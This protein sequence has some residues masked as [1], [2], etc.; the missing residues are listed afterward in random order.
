MGLAT[1]DAVFIRP[2]LDVTGAPVRNPTFVT[3]SDGG[4]RNAYELRLRNKHG[5]PRTFRVALTGDPRLNLTLEGTPYQAI[6][7]PADAT[8]KLRVYVTAPPSSDPA[9]ADVTG[10]RFWIED[11]ANGDRAYKDSTFNGKGRS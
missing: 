7:V 11:L 9:Q 10:F 2:D 8:H 5:E 3:L 6:E 4:V 1:T